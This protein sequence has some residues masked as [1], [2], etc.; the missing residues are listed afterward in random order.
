[1]RRVVLDGTDVE[2]SVLGLGTAALGGRLRSRERVA[3]V[4]AALAAGITHFDTA[5]LYAFGEAEEALGD[6]LVGRS[7]PVT[8]ATKIG[9]TPAPP[10]RRRDVARVASRLPG[11]R[12][13]VR[14][15][16][17]QPQRS[18]ALEDVRRSFE[19]SLRSL[20]RDHVDLLLLH[21]A[22]AGDI[23]RP[24]LREWLAETVSSG[25]AR[26]IGIATSDTA[27]RSVVESAAPLAQIVQVA[28]SASS[29]QVEDL[30]R[31][32]RIG[33][34]THSALAQDLPAVTA[35]FARA[36]DRR[37]FWADRLGRD[38]DDASVVA[39][40]LLAGALSRNAAGGVIFGTR[41]IENVRINAGAGDVRLTHA[42][43]T[44]LGELAVEA[45][46]RGPRSASSL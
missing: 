30:L 20:R 12:R 14:G 22:H 16:W 25:R 24:G 19:T 17:I 46:R 7:E 3:L 15:R 5:P 37:R 43:T 34:I 2:V 38:L 11:A 42:Q 44:A 13:L 21:E 36:P 6:A 8:V 26:A 41:K 39:Q 32:T 29:P 35:H 28:D 18:F 9:L 33:A 1:M 10:G 23:D 31:G 27:A 4:H 40:L 45:A